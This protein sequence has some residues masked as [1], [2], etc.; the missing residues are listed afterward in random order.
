MFEKNRNQ[1]YQKLEELG[2]PSHMH[3]AMVRYLVDHIAPG[4]FL[5]AV[6]ENDLKEACNRADDI[7]ILRLPEYVRFLYNFAPRACWGSPRAFR[8]WLHV[9]IPTRVEEEASRW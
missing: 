7:N 9:E 8:E 3:G 6:L 1:L 2:I 5:Q 4:D